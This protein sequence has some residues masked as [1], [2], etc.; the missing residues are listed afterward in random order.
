MGDAAGERAEAIHFLRVQ[1]LPFH[2]E[3]G[4]LGAFAVG[5]VVGDGKDAH[6]AVGQCDPGFAQFI[7]AQA[8]ILLDVGDFVVEN[9]AG[10]HPGNVSVDD[11]GFFLADLRHVQADEIFAGVTHGAAEIGI[12]VAD[13]AFGIQQDNAA[14]HEFEEGAVLR[15]LAFEGIQKP[16]LALELGFQGGQL[17]A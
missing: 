12:G 11:F 17:P 6:G 10:D 2:V 7:E 9:F 4:L 1:E 16:L 3:L 14:G 8:A 15:R 5:D 13:V